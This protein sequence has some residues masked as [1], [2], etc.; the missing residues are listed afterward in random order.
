MSDKKGLSINTAPLIE[1][2]Q[3]PDF[4]RTTNK[5]PSSR[6]RLQRKRI[7][8]AVTNRG[9]RYK[10]S[11]DLQVLTTDLMKKNERKKDEFVYKNKT[12]YYN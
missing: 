7:A 9:M 1:T 3:P 8:G 2:L 6:L 12:L 5:V 4:V 10:N 11:Q